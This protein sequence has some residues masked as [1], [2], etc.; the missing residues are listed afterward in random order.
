MKA[1]AD[2]KETTIY[3]Y[4]LIQ[5]IHY[6]PLSKS[7]LHSIFGVYCLYM[8]MLL[9]WM[10]L[11]WIMF[12]FIFIWMVHG[13]GL[14]LICWRGGIPF[15][16][17]WRFTWYPMHYGFIP[18]VDFYPLKSYRIMIGNMALIGFIAAAAAYPW[19]PVQGLGVH[20]IVIHIWMILF[21]LTILLRFSRYPGHYL[22]KFGQKDTFLYKQ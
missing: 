1:V 14:F 18:N 6:S 21:R 22:I 10:S 13:A 9:G 7:L 3:Q 19:I 11:I 15:L 16:E 5:K 12:S 4:Q 17:H 8:V 20:I 2:S